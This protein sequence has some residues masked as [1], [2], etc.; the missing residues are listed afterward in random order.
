MTVDFPQ[1]GR[2]LPVF[3]KF[4][5]SLPNLHTLEIGWADSRITAP[6]KNALKDAKFPWIKTLIFPPTAYPLLRHCRGVESVVYVIRDR[7]KLPGGLI[8]T[9]ESNLD[10]KVKQLTIPL[11]M[12]TD[13][14]RK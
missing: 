6:L 7:K 10:S 3:I 5:R 8:R 11:A 13:L 14:S 12:W 9:L 1:Y 4:L 2:S